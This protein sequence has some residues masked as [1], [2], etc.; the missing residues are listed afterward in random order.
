VSTPANRYVDVVFLD[1]NGSP[2]LARCA[3]LFLDLLGVTEMATSSRAAQNLVELE[4]AIRGVVRDFLDSATFWPAAMFSDMIVMA[5]PVDPVVGEE[6]AIAGL[7]MQ[8]S[9]LQLSLA[10][11]GFFARGSIAVGDFYLRD[12]VVFGAALVD[13]YHLERDKAIHPRVILSDEVHVTQRQ[14]L[15]DYEKRR[16]TPLT[17]L[18][19]RD[20]DGQAFLNYLELL[21]EEATDPR[22]RLA[23]HR[24]ALAGKLEKHRDDSHVWEKYR[25]VSEY[26]NHF[27][28]ERKDEDW[29]TPDLLIPGADLVSRAVNSF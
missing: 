10:E 15:K 28:N 19:L 3:L 11:R 6:A 2:Q 22:P 17:T 25:W 26:H 29:F 24:D 13:A 1:A 8:A 5:S 4:Q 12:E 16:G 27:C 23:R 9:W 20:R 21:L 14:N 18:L 7:L